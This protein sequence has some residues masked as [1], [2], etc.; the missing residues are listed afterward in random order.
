MQDS[1]SILTKQE[2]K[3][4]LKRKKLRNSEIL[5]SLKEEFGEEPEN[6]SSSG[7][8]LE[9]SKEKELELEENERK[10]FEEERFIRLVSCHRVQLLFEVFKVNFVCRR[11]LERRSNQ[12]SGDELMLHD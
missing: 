6:F 3:I 9:N 12:L 4:E 1:E 5:A 2:K 11:C 10:D 8:S 7:V